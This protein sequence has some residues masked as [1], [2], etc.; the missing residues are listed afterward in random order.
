VR[1][2]GCIAEH[3]ISS[4]HHELPN[5]GFDVIIVDSNVAMFNVALKQMLVVCGVS[6]RLA[7]FTF[8]R[9]CA[10]HPK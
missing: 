1:A 7:E 9:A 8:W 4:A 10:K 5:E 6:E 3:P 2:V